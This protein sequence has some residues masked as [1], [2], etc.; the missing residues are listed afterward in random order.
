MRK[1]AHTTSRG[2]TSLPDLGAFFR[3]AS[4]ILD[5]REASWVGEHPRRQF[6]RLLRAINDDDFPHDRYRTGDSGIGRN[7]LV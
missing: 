5:H 2:N 3:A 4:Q 7:G 1:A 6:N